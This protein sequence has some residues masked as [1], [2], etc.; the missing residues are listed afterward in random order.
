M[1]P[2]TH[3][4]MKRLFSLKAKN[5]LGRFAPSTCL[6][7]GRDVNEAKWPHTCCRPFALEEKKSKI[8]TIKNPPRS[9]YATISTAARRPR[10]PRDGARR[11]TSHALAHTHPLPQIPGLWKSASYSS[12]DFLWQKWIRSLR[13]LGPLLVER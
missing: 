1:A 6:I 11:N 3:P 12:R 13:S 9:K 5:G 8:K 10:P 7:T 4:G 2:C